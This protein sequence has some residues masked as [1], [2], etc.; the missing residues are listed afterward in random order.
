MFVTMQT[1]RN[2]TYNLQILLGHAWILDTRKTDMRNFI[3]LSLIAIAQILLMCSCAIT[4]PFDRP[5][6]LSQ[7]ANPVQAS[8]DSGNKPAADKEFSVHQEIKPTQSIEKDGLLISY[9]ILAMPDNKDT[10][11]RV[12][13]VFR[14]LQDRS[15]IVRPKVSLLDASGKK[16]SPYT[17]KQFIRISSRLA[18]KTSDIVTQSIDKNDGNGKVS[19]KS[20]IE[21]ANTYWLKQSYKIPAQGIAI[22]ELV[23]RDTHLDLPMKLTVNASKQ[24]FVFTTKDSLPVADK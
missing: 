1:G 5:G 15:R 11:I 21:W 14:N 2:I 7:D 6:N 22:G 18:G 12:S 4:S 8:G 19:E 16:I 13:L 17:K 23:Y 9:S 10:L 3:R 20:R 24:E